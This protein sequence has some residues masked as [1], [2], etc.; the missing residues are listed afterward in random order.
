M[1]PEIEKLRKLQETEL[2]IKYYRERID[3][4][5]RQLAE[6]EAKL[7]GTLQALEA[8]RQKIAKTASDKKRLEGNIQDLEQRNSKYRAQLTDVKTN[9]QYKALVHEIEF[10]ENQVRKIEDDI[11]LLMEEDEELR[12]GSQNLQRQLEK[13]KA[14]VEAEKK[15]A[16]AE[17]TKDKTLV[18]E[19]ASQREGIIQSVDP[20]ILTTYERIVKVRKGVALARAT[21]GSCQACHVRIRPHVISQVM[22]GESIVTCDSCSRILYWDADAPYE[23]VP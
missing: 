23:V 10:N 6:L 11:L 22:S 18:Q 3:L 4:L 9:E 13:E 19:L 1:H 12:K 8:N 16:E 20:G 7:N 21:Q 14:L 15:T 17:V 5:P 2:Q